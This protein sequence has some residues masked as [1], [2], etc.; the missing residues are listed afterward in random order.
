MQQTPNLNA[1]YTASSNNQPLNAGML[2]GKY[3]IFT[4]G[5]NPNR[6]NK[7][8]KQRA[9]QDLLIYQDEPMYNK[10]INRHLRKQW[11]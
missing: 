6:G 2:V 8:D 5:G 3:R 9:S 10:T 1:G 11:Q 7:L 4:T